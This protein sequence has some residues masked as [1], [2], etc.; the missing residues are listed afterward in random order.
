M[1]IGPTLLFRRLLPTSAAVDEYLFLQ[2]HDAA[3]LAVALQVVPADPKHVPEVKPCFFQATR[4]ATRS[5][6]VHSDD[7]NDAVHLAS[8]QLNVPFRI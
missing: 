4:Q 2:R 5:A 8:C 3:V 6:A 7:A 1:G